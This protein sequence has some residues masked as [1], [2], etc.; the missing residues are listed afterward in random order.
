MAAQ[1]D[2]LILAYNNGLE[3]L[4]LHIANHTIL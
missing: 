1:F 2:S 4:A 3:E